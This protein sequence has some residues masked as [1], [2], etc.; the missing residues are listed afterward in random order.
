MSDDIE[1]VD[2]VHDLLKAD[3]NLAELVDWK[4]ANGLVS[5]ATSGCS[6]GLD[7]EGF[8]EYTRD[9]DET[10]GSVRILIW[11]KMVDPVTAEAKIRKQAK[12]ARQVLVK[13]RTLGGA[14]ANSYLNKIFYATADAG[15][16][17]I[18]HMADLD[19]QVKYYSPRT[20]PETQPIEHI[21]NDIGTEQ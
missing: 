14:V 6:V 7:E 3:D 18:L 15:K 5:L 10:V 9:K 19:F 4:K 8:N 2:L 1:I 12:A 11:V 21:N 13:N 20:W 16:N 17:L